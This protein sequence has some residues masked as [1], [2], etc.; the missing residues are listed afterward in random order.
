MGLRIGYARVS[1]ASE[2]QARSLEGQQQDLAK[3]GC[4]QVIA[5]SISAYGEKRRPGWEKLWGL[6]ADGLVSE[7]IVVDQSR[8]SRSGDDLDFLNACQM[9]G[10][11]VR[12]LSGG[13]IEVETVGGYIQAGILS[14]M[15]RAQSKLIGIKVKDGIRRRRAAGYLA[16]GNLPFGYAHID[17]KAAPHPQNFAVARTAFD[18]LLGEGMNIHGWLRTGAPEGFPA[19]RTGVRRWLDHEM[20]RGRAGGEWGTVP[21]LISFE[22]HRRAMAMLQ[23]RSSVRGRN[24]ARLR[25]F[26]GL[27]SCDACGKKLS[28]QVDRLRCMNP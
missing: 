2:H 12:A 23:A 9:K 21:A 5:E 4:D 7:V 18:G 24:T 14:V 11:V 25:L 10:V 28:T 13:A 20:L 16:T 22:E 6:V 27:V 1:T 8:L 17:G 15:N 3:A 26:S 19:T